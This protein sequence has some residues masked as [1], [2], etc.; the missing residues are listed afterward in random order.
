MKTEKILNYKTRYKNLYKKLNIDY[1]VI[2]EKIINSFR[3]NDDYSKFLFLDHFFIKNKLNNNFRFNL[4]IY[5]ESN[6]IYIDEITYI[7]PSDFYKIIINNLNPIIPFW[8][9][10]IK[11]ISNTLFLPTFENIEKIPIP[12]TFNCDKNYITEHYKSKILQKNIEYNKKRN[13]ISKNSKSNIRAR[14]I[15]M[16]LNKDQRNG[17]NKIFGIYR[18]FYNRAIQFINNYSKDLNSTSILIDTNNIF[19]RL[20]FQFENRENIFSINNM[21]KYLKNNLPE[22]IDLNIPS[23]LIDQSFSEASNNYYKCMKK[24]KKNHKPFTLKF[25][26]KKDVYQTINIEK[27]MISKDK[28]SIFKNLKWN[29]KKVFE[30]INFSENIN[31]FHI[32]DSSISCNTRLNI[33]YLNINYKNKEKANKK[34]LENNKI[35]SIDPGNRT[36]LSI[37][38]DNEINMIGNGILHKIEKICKEI[39]ILN[40]K[41]NKRKIENKNQYKYNKNKRRNYKKAMFRKIEYLKNIKKDLHHKSIKYLCDNYSKIITAPFEIQEMSQKLNS[42]ISRNM[43][44]LSYYSFLLKLKKKCER[45]DIVLDIKNESYTSKTCTNCGNIKYNLGSNKIYKCDL[46]KIS[47]DR[48]INGARNIMLKNNI[49]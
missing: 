26:T 38:S 23:H 43:Y 33:Y 30:K 45:Y 41:I 48:D 9:N 2:F 44:C 10:K 11:D 13:F 40:S 3:L 14:K 20:L 17:M 7:I 1:V 15:K 42:K 34:I 24:Y 31:G 5:S 6:N 46:C 36:F 35:C 27:C 25:K 4:D 12:K 49:W 39:D 28:K 19:S 22:W 47:I 29:N 32:L 21:R 8:N 18:Y 16:F 37:Y